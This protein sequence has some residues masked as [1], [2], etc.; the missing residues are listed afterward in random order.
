MTTTKALA[1]AKRNRPKK[2]LTLSREALA[3]LAIIA[4]ERGT[5]ESGAVEQLIRN[6]RIS[7]D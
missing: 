2:N 6:A 3:R 5:T 1:P 7:K 4:E